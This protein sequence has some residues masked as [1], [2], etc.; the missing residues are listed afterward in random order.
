MISLQV[1]Y[2]IELLCTN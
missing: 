2:S 1:I